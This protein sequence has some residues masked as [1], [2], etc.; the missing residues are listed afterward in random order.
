MPSKHT[1]AHPG[2]NAAAARI[3]AIEGMSKEHARAVLASSSR[4]AS[5]KAKKRNPR[6]NRVKG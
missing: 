5:A 3:A 2:F 4:N 1:K 6:L